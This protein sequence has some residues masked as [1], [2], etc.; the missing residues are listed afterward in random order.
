MNFIYVD[1]GTHKNRICMVDPQKGRIIV[2]NRGVKSARFY[3]LKGA[4]MPAVL[5]EI[6]FISNHTDA[7][8]L[9]SNYYREKLVDAIAGGILAYKKRFEKSNGFTE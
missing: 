4:H 5:L 9:K 3:V 8:S 7:E 6:G 2:K 1:G